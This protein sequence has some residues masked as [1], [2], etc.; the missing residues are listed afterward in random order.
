MSP[1]VDWQLKFECVKVLSG[2]RWLHVYTVAQMTVSTVQLRW[3]TG[4]SVLPRDMRAANHISLFVFIRGL[5]CLLSMC[6][7]TSRLSGRMP[8]SRRPWARFDVVSC[9]RVGC[10]PASLTKKPPEETEMR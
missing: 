5:A 6:S 1:R 3:Q 10:L 7:V 9:V 8:E 4:V 2:L